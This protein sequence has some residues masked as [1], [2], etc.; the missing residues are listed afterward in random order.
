M[1][2]RARWMSKPPLARVLWAFTGF[3][4]GLV[5]MY[6]AMILVAIIGALA[7]VLS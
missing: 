4:V 3:A 5:A 6:A 2:L 7:V 1:T